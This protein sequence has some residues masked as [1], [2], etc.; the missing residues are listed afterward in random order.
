MFFTVIML[1]IAAAVLAI[2]VYAI[3]G[4][5]GKDRGR[6]GKLL[7]SITGLYAGVAI[8]AYMASLMH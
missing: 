6:T 5:V 3:N 8:L 4:L 1:A 2:G 7:L